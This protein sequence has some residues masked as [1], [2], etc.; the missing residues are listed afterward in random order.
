MSDWIAEK[1]IVTARKYYHCDACELIV[2]DD[3]RQRKVTFAE[4]RQIAKAKHQNWMI[5]K[6]QKYVYERIF[7]DGGWHTSRSIPEIQAICIKYNYYE[8]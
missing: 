7:Y 6:G 8:D 2:N 4:W 5:K 3:Y 1:K